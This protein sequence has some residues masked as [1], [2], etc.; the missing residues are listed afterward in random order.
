M[1]KART[2]LLPGTALDRT[3]NDKRPIPSSSKATRG[4]S[5]A[6]AICATLGLAACGHS[7][8]KAPCEATEGA[9]SYAEVPRDCG[10]MRRVNE[11]FA[12]IKHDTI[13]ATEPLR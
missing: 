12:A 10:P 7:D 4:R 13:A 5:R 3:A 1:R 9:L 2:A 8:L 6:L 11:P